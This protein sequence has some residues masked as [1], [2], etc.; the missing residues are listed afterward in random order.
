[1][2]WDAAR[3]QRRRCTTAGF[4]SATEQPNGAL[5]G[6]FA[7][8]SETFWPKPMPLPGVS[9]GVDGGDAVLTVEV[10]ASV[11]S[12]SLSKR[13]MAEIGQTIFDLT[14]PGAAG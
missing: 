7:A 12:F 2:R 4:R 13:S 3:C 6:R 11:L 1:M 9:L 10:G 8:N 14:R 5:N